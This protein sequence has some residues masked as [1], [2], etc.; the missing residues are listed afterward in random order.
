LP[1]KRYFFRD[2]IH[3]P[4]RVIGLFPD[5]FAPR[6]AD[7]PEQTVLTGF[8]R[9]DE[10]DVSQA[11]GPWRRFLDEGDAPIVF[12]PG[13][14]M[15]HGIDFFRAAAEACQLLGRRG[16]LLSRYSAQLP[17]DLPPSVRHF[18]F[19]PF[20]SLLPRAA[21]LVHHGGVGTLSQGL[22]AGVPQ[23]IMPM[24][25]DQPDNAERLRRLGV[26]AALSRRRFRAPAVAAALE[27]LISSSLV[28]ES[29]RRVADRFRDDASIDQTCRLIEE[30]IHAPAGRTAAA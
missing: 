15:V 14:A 30:L 18:D 2:W 25:F 6:Q 3:S 7:W 29:C 28:A 27:Q 17:T 21:A 5:W 20:S 4:Q 12:T 1:A 9:Y 16:V 13:S 22:A 24:S 8:P 11:D 23:L 10:A 19:V 26:G